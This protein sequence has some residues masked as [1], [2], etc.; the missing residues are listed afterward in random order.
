M[1]KKAEPKALSGQNTKVI[2]LIKKDGGYGYVEIE[3]PQEVV[4]SGKVLSRS[5][6]DIYAI[7]V[8][9]MTKKT[10]DIFEI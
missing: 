9:E 2:H 5:E 10:R 7:F 4:E 3:L 8:N 6:P 1:A